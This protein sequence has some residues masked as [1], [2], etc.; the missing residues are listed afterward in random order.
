MSKGLIECRNALLEEFE[1]IVDQCEAEIRGLSNIE[2]TRISEIKAEIENIDSTIKAKRESRNLL[3][4]TNTKDEVHNVETREKIERREFEEHIRGLS[5]TNNG[6]L[7]P[8]SV[9]EEIVKEVYNQA[10]LLSM[11]KIYNV[12]GD[13][14][15]DIQDGN[16]NVG[17][18]DEL[19]ESSDIEINLKTKTLKNNGIRVL[20]KISNQLIMDSNVDVVAEVIA[21]VASEL[22]KFINDTLVCGALGKVEG[23]V[24]TTNTVEMSGESVGLEDI[25]ALMMAVPTEKADKACFIMAPSVMTKIRT[26]ALA[27]GVLA[28]GGIGQDFGT[29][30][31]GKR[32][33]LVDAMEK[34][35]SKVVFANVAEGYAVKMP[36]NINITLI[37]ELF[38][39]QGMTGI[40]A[41]AY[42][43]A[44]IVNTKLVSSLVEKAKSRSSK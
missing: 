26:E 10:P 23:L 11:S 4:I 24:D 8:I 20:T 6:G 28:F 29:T 16:I 7:I 39:R 27:K 44:A 42:F 40:H 32:V 34:A 21:I 38:I 25:I 9:A 13:L 19:T 1:R 5:V 12:V 35:K 17:F 22:A 30:L 2:N 41:Q 14:T 3:T 31:F 36:Q 43:D 37:K 15:I 33:Y 18:V